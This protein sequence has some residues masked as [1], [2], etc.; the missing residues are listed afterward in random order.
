MVSRYLEEIGK[1][2]RESLDHMILLLSHLPGPGHHVSHGPGQ[3]SLGSLY[4]SS[5]VAYNNLLIKY[6]FEL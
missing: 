4:H 5:T 2:S 6:N 1:S 3:V